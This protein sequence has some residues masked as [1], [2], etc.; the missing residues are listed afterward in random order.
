MGLNQEIQHNLT[1]KQKFLNCTK[2][3]VNGNLFYVY[4]KKIVS[5]NTIYS[6]NLCGVSK[7]IN[8]ND[9]YLHDESVLHRELSKLD[10]VP[11]KKWMKECIVSNNLTRRECNKKL[12]LVLTTNE[13]DEI[14]NEMNFHS[15]NTKNRHDNVET[16]SK[17]KSIPKSYK[18]FSKTYESSN[19]SSDSDCENTKYRA[20]NRLRSFSEGDRTTVRTF[21]SMCRQLTSLEDFLE[22]DLKN[23]VKELFLKSIE[24]ERNSIGSSNMLLTMETLDFLFTIKTSLSKRLDTIPYKFLRF[25]NLFYDD[26][27]HFTETF[28]VKT[29]MLKVYN[30]SGNNIARK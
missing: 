6:C 2:E 16:G 7:I 29:K 24:L 20:V 18:N 10:S 13:L 25:I 28:A 15:N 21:L 22:E 14:E 9:L 19:E 4:S 5:S 1:I 8:E 30:N 26:M 23:G 27:L 11:Y 17:K 12:K 3:L